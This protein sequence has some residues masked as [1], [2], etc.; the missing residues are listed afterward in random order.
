VVDFTAKKGQNTLAKQVL[1]I[2]K[3]EKREWSGAIFGCGL[4]FFYLTTWGGY[5]YLGLASV[6]LIIH[7]VVRSLSTRVAAGFI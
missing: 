3:W 4:L 5:T 2:L 1:D 6:L 7:I